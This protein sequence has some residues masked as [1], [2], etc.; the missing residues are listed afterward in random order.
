MLVQTRGAA[1]QIRT[2]ALETKIKGRLGISENKY[3]GVNCLLADEET[4][5]LK[6][7][8]FLDDKDR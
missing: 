5:K 4:G 3:T 6:D 1:T 7:S 8:F 2:V